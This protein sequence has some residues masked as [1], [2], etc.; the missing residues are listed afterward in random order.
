MSNHDEDHTHESNHTSQPPNAAQS[1]AS[2]TRWANVQPPPADCSYS[3]RACA[4]LTVSVGCSVEHV[5]GAGEHLHAGLQDGV[6]ALGA[7]A[8]SS[9]NQRKHRD[10]HNM[11]RRQLMHGQPALGTVQGAPQSWLHACSI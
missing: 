9:R 4:L 3:R 5:P 2:K 6:P 1:E 7:R 10:R 11:Q 8:C